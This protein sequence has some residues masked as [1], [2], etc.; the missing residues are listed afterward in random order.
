MRLLKR[1]SPRWVLGLLGVV[2]LCNVLLLQLVQFPLGE[3]QRE[4]DG[5]RQR[6]HEASS[7]ALSLYRDREVL[8][9]SVRLLTRERDSLLA[10]A[11]AAAPSAS[12]SESSTEAGEANDSVE[13]LLEQVRQRSGEMAGLLQRQASRALQLHIQRNQNPPSCSLD[14]GYVWRNTVTTPSTKACSIS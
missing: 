14:G 9:E 4:T 13:R 11:A 3:K 6:A 1:L 7:L 2:L 8:Q 12:S 10:A 5:V